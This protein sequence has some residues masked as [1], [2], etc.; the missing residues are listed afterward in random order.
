MFFNMLESASEV[1]EETEPSTILREVLTPPE[2]HD[3]ARS[4]LQDLVEYVNQLRSALD[5][6]Q[7]APA[8]GHVPYFVSYFWQLH[9]PDTYPIYYTSMRD[10]LAN[11]EIWTPSGDHPN[12]YVEF[13]ELNEE[14]RDVLESHTGEQ[15]HLWDIERLCLFWLNR[16]AV[17]SPQV[18]V[19]KAKPTEWNYGDSGSG[20]AFGEALWAP[21]ENKDGQRIYERLR[22]PAIGD[23]VLHLSREDDAIVGTSVIE[24]DLQTDFEIPEDAEWSAEQRE[25]GGYLRELKDYRDLTPPFSVRE[26]LLEVE[27]LEPSLRRIAEDNSVFY[28]ESLTFTPQAYVTEAPQELVEILARQSESLRDR[29]S[30]LG[31]DLDGTTPAGEY[32]TISE[33]TDDVRDRLDSEE[34]DETNLLNDAITTALIE[35]WTTMLSGF[36]PNSEVSPADDVRGKQILQLYEDTQEQFQKQAAALGV[37]ELLS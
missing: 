17:S 33:A 5:E 24:S 22:E 23:V 6:G 27:Q 26:E 29:L 7:S 35:E 25:T 30:E 28:T 20:F 14:I 36:E 10:A 9:D 18:W 1:D 2:D 11:L 3:T 31:Y 8:V 15:I 19:E 32:E 4:C 13:W 12:D 16:D 34:G 37:G 21:Q